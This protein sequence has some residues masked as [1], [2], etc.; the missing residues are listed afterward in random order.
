[1]KLAF[2]EEGDKEIIDQDEKEEFKEF[3]EE[4]VDV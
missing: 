2:H 4:K 1:M 3:K